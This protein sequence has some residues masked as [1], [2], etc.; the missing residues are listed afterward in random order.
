MRKT[1]PVLEV[2]RIEE[3]HSVLSGL[4]VIGPTGRLNES[5]RS[6]INQP[7]DGCH[8]FPKIGSSKGVQLVEPNFRDGSSEHMPHIPPANSDQWKQ[9]YDY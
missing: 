6:I 2:P 1:L 8:Q 9:Q 3:S 4:D 7:V 5:S